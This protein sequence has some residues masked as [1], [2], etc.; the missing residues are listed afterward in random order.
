MGSH[1]SVGSQEEKS[2]VGGAARRNCRVRWPRG[3]EQLQ[4]MFGI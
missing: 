3:E 4:I 1:L 2:Q